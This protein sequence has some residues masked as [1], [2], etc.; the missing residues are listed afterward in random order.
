MEI[1]IVKSLHEIDENDLTQNRSFVY[2]CERDKFFMLLKIKLSSG[3]QSIAKLQVD[4]NDLIK[5]LNNNLESSQTPID[6]IHI[7]IL[8]SNRYFYFMELND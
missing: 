6:D 2:C 7:S 3:K 4:E 5:E 1:R 8:S